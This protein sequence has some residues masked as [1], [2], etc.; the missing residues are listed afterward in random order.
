V[1]PSSVDDAELDALVIDLRA[2]KARHAG[3][4]PPSTYGYDAVVPKSWRSSTN[5]GGT[6]H[7]R[8]QPS[9]SEVA[10]PRRFRLKQRFPPLQRVVHYGPIDGQEVDVKLTVAQSILLHSTGIENPM[11]DLDGRLRESDHL[12][13]L[14]DTFG[15]DR[16]S[17]G[18]QL[19][20]TARTLDGA[21]R[22]WHKSIVAR[23][24]YGF[25]VRAGY[26]VL[27]EYRS[28]ERDLRQRS[29]GIAYKR[30]VVAYQIELDDVDRHP[31]QQHHT[32]AW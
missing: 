27:L 16:R 1:D 14:T 10:L 25:A 31:R 28:P 23:N 4:R 24:R 7:R 26:L 32:G 29:F 18:S 5:T 13:L 8:E 30:I 21:K 19:T 11:R 12:Q 3:V 2:R 17:L 22:E 20:R 6:P 15:R 9:K